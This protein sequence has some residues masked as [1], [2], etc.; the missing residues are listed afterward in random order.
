MRKQWCM[1]GVAALIALTACGEVEGGAVCTDE[2]NS[3]RYVWY[4]EDPAGEPIEEFYGSLQREDGEDLAFDCR[5]SESFDPVDFDGSFH[6]AALGDSPR[7]LR[8]QFFGRAPEFTGIQVN[9]G[10]DQYSFEGPLEL[11]IERFTPRCGG[12]YRTGTVT[13]V[14]E[15]EG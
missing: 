13:V 12:G 6:C 2:M 8:L 4:F 5:E 15:D 14:L 3:S 11:E 7:A 10:D 1:S 9:S